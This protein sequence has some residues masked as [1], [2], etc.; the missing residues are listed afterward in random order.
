MTSSTGLSVGETAPAFVA[1]LVQPDGTTGMTRLSTLLAD[2]PVLLCFYTNDFTPD[3]IGEWCSFRDYA[4]FDPEDGRVSV[5][6]VSK[7]L[8]RTHEKFMG[9]FDIDFPL[10]S[11]PGL[12]VAEGF[13][14]KYRAFKLV[15]RSR[16][17]CFLID[18]DRTVR[19]RWLGDH[20][21]D[22]TMDRPPVE[23][24]SADIENALA[25]G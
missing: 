19:Y 1:P 4:W 6:G 3:C 11:D 20:P 5:V 14:V 16:R 12:D 18:P 9:A 22:P 23:Q 8:P 13:G 7:S 15:P 25:E 17:S 24:L 10:Y 21:I 2:K